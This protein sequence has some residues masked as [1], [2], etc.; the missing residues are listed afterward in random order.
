MKPTPNLT[1]LVSMQLSMQLVSALFLVALLRTL[2]THLPRRQFFWFWTW[3]WMAYVV[4][5]GAGYGWLSVEKT[6]VFSRHFLLASGIIASFL[7]AGLL[8]LGSLSLR[9]ALS[10]RRIRATLLFFSGAGV[11]L[12]AAS[13]NISLDPLFRHAIRTI[14]RQGLL[15]VSYIICG[16]LFFRFSREMRSW[17]AGII[18]SVCCV[19]A[20]VHFLL[21][22][23]LL[24]WVWF[25]MDVDSAIDVT[26]IDIACM[27]GIGVGALRVL[28]E[29]HEAEAKERRF[30]EIA[31]RVSE[32]KFRKAFRSSPHPMV[33][34]MLPDGR[35]L[36]ANESF[37][38]FSGYAREEVLG[39]TSSELGRWV[40]P[41]D[42]ARLYASLNSLGAYHMVSRFRV[43]TGEIRVA[44][45]AGEIFELEGQKCLLG[46]LRDVTEQLRATEA[47]RRSEERYRDLFENAN[48]IIYTHDLEGNFTSFNKAGE[49]ITGYTRGDLIGRNLSTL[50]EPQQIAIAREMIA[51]KLAGEKSTVYQLQVRSKGGH[52]LTLEISTR[53]I[54]QDGQPL[55]VEGIARD[56][57]D[58]M[59]TEEVVRR[60]HQQMTFHLENSP[61]AYL[62]WHP[63]HG[64]RSWSKKA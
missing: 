28:L 37:L 4:S 64:V 24:V 42:R 30:A 3:A 19:N 40:D 43:K 14:S 47:L 15:G 58:R 20:M 16:F 13:G 52:P 60:T 21:A 39:H 1:D 29:E 56:L 61:L 44:E 22:K 55:G 11:I 31:L 17:G 59:K 34:T 23:P 26:L 38:H 54:F 7:Q 33:I 36:D 63:Q 62:E 41:A 10:E 6:W 12:W 45:V 53:I 2:Q 48:D 9:N 25:G 35:Y 27:F 5:L 32:D 51:R 8:L 49:R 46:V 18:A 57:T 50:A